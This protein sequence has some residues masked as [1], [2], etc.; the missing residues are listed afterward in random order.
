M[1][2]AERS[3]KFVQRWYREF[4]TFRSQGRDENWDGLAGAQTGR[5]D[6]PPGTVQCSYRPIS[7]VA[8]I[9]A[10]NSYVAVRSFADRL[11]DFVSK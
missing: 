7:A 2:A 8:D 6:A 3:S 10:L 4:Q 9:T 5:D 11:G 1:I